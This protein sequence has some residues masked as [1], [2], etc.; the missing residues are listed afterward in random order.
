MR[1]GKLSTCMIVNRMHACV[2]LYMISLHMHHLYHEL[3]IRDMV[4]PKKLVILPSI[5]VPL[6]WWVV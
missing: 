6:M 5:K 3:W 1:Q 2:Q 4:N